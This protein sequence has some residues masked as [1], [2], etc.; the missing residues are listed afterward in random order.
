[1][2]RLCWVMALL[3]VAAGAAA[4]EEATGV[5]KVTLGNGLRVLL[6]PDSQATA[7]DV[8]VWYRAGTLY[9]RPGKYGITYLL[10]HLM[11]RGSRGVPS[12]E[13]RRRLEAEGASVNSVTNP[14]FTCFYETLPPEALDLALRL[15][16]DRMGALSITQ[17]ALDQERHKAR[18]ERRL[19][20]ESSPPGRGLQELYSEAFTGYPY[21]YPV[22]GTDQDLEGIS[23]ADVQAYYRERFAPGNAL[24]TLVGR[25]DPAT[26]LPAVRRHF[27]ALP[28]RGTARRAFCCWRD[29]AAPGTPTR[30]A[31]RSSCSPTSSAA[32]AP[33]GSPVACWGRR[34]TSCACRVSSIGCA[35]PRSSTAWR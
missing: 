8:G 5:H 11:F 21:A 4:G 9:E 10:G 31:P 22:M 15:E 16:A 3:G 24:V 17:R 32:G 34:R 26:A 6:A 35:T 2:K 7:V 25:F 14:D 29:G 27:E 13:H 1:M 23:L 28:S 18:E 30:T 20:V 19:R 33:P 12:G